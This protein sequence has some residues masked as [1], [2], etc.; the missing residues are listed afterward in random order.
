MLWMIWFQ[1]V[2]TQ[3]EQ[4][5]AT[6]FFHCFSVSFWPVLYMIVNYPN[7][8]FTRSF[9]ALHANKSNK[10]NNKIRKNWLPLPTYSVLQLLKTFHVYGP[11][12]FRTSLGT[13]ILLLKKCLRKNV[14]L[15]NFCLYVYNILALSLYSSSLDREKRGIERKGYLLWICNVLN[16]FIL[17]LGI[18][19]QIS[20]VIIIIKLM[21]YM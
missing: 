5:C 20:E 16:Y 13:S 10:I 4:A 21:K 6:N 19:M 7:T 9:L 12:E 18:W 11:F 2:K 3:T 8:W 17:P 14:V 15:L 1:S